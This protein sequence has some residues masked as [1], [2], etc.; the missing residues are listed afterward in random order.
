MADYNA[1]N[2]KGQYVDKPSSKFP[3]GENA[4]RK[5]LLLDHYTTNAID[6]ALTGGGVDRVL[7]PKIPAS[8][9]VTDAKIYIDGTL[10]IGGIFDLGFLA[11]GVDATDVD[12]FVT[13][14]DG[15]GQAALKRADA[16]NVGV[17]KRFSVET[18]LVLSCFE[19]T[20][21]AGVTITF[22][23]EYVND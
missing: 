8:S 6:G 9:I 17:F 3:K 2:Y 16:S 14:A 20:A 1:D 15:G 4:G 5:R 13:G 11:N 19:T 10:G 12:A 22:E 23:I 18:Q 21:N 7:G